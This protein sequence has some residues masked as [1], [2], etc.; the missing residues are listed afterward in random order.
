MRIS[1]VGSC[2]LDVLHELPSGGGE[3]RLAPFLSRAEGDG[4]LRRGGAVIRRL[5][6]DRHRR[7]TA[8]LVREL[9]GGP[10][11][12]TQGGVAAASLIAAAQL[13]R[14][15]DVEVRLYS[16]LS[17]DEGGD[18]VRRAL[19]RTPLSAARLGKRHGRCP[20]TTILNERA[21]DGT[22]ERSFITEP[23]IN[24][25]LA[26]DP[27]ELDREFFESE[28]TLFAGIRWEPWLCADLT[29]LLGECRRSGS[30]T[31]VGTAFD[32]TLGGGRGRWLLGDSDEAYEHLD[33]LVMDLTEAL[34]HSGEPD[35]GRA[36]AFFRR[37]GVRAFAVTQGVEEVYYWAGGGAF[38]PA[39]GTLPIPAA[40]QKDKAS[41]N[42]PTGDSVGCGDS[43]LGGMVASAALQ[44]RRGG[45]LDL[46]EA[47]VL[48]NLSGGVAS[49]HAGGVLEEKYP[50]EKR[51]LVERYRRLYEEQLATSSAASAGGEPQ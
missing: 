34:G 6:E 29:R 33:L 9:G 40:I 17:D 49:T 32:T 15:R 43:F 35:L 46:R 18:Q 23:C 30:L 3:D 8:E 20:S 21:A 39:E 10:P 37:S 47:V 27:R 25:E 2:V 1:G 5:L 7:T 31:V 11:R 4:G 12:Y 50:G 38:A 41:G 16:N 51:D 22:A 44:L 13:L 36:A 24:E 14:G 26:Y 42:L 48:G 28:V 19:S 45:P